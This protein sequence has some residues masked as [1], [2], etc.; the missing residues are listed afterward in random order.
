MGGP[1]VGS[2][3]KAKE[4]DLFGVKF[5]GV[6]KEKQMSVLFFLFFERCTF[7]K[8]RRSSHRFLIF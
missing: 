1:E 4:A 6:F 5:L 3:A 2:R 7:L 8:D